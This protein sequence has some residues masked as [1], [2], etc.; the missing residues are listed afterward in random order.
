MKLKRRRPER[1]ELREDELEAILARAESSLEPADHEK[2]KAAIETLAWLTGELEAKNV[3]LARLRKILFGAKTEKTRGVVP[4]EGG[5]SPG[6]DREELSPDSEEGPA[7]R[8]PPPQA[9]PRQGHGR[10]GAAAYTG[11]EKVA[12]PHASL[13]PGDPCPACPK[14]K[15]Y[16]L[17]PRVLVRV[18]GQPPL[19]AT[20]YE[21][22]RVPS[23]SVPDLG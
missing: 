14:G 11:A 20:V 3:S 9:P 10:N 22:D 17:A 8:D 2:L 7:P 5:G 13:C 16:R 4:R 19:Q 15:V 18:R 1:I 21:L 6:K 12:V 23:A